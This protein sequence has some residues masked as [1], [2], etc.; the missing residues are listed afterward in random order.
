MISIV[1]LTYNRQE[2]LL[3]NI[4]KIRRQTYADKEIIVVDNGNNAEIR[5]S[6]KRDSPDVMYLPMMSNIACAGRNAGIKAAKGEIV[7]TLDDDVLFASDKELEKVCLFFKERKDVHALNFKIVFVDDRKIIP[8]NWYHPRDYRLYGDTEFETDYIGEGATAFRKMIF[9]NSGYYPEDFFLSHEGPDLAYR[10]I[11]AGYTI[12][13]TPSVEVV[14]MVD[15]R[16]R[17]S[18][19]NSYYDTRNQVW[20]GIRNF[21]LLMLIRHIIY[22][23]IT[24]FL[25]CLFRGHIIWYIIAIRDAIAGIPKELK[26]RK[27]ITK[28]T[29][30]KLKNIRRLNPG[31][32]QKM[33]DFAE[34]IHLV[35]GYYN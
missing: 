33:F 14:H 3:E 2:V 7:V 20:L 22:R 32:F 1:I 19:R 6:M 30:K 28:K 17:P 29:I 16:N 21:P 8:F 31:F 27:P 35:K 9:S 18:W 34:K 13:Y 24:T 4:D 12:Y 10:I 26:Y 25:F 15:R 11:N 5:E 23:S